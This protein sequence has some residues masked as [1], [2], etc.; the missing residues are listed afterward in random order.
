MG[1]GGDPPL[2]PPPSPVKQCVDNQYCN[3][4]S[5]SLSDI[6]NIGQFDGADSIENVSTSSSEVSSDDTVDATDD[7]IGPDNTPI[8]LTPVTKPRGQ[9]LKVLKASS[10]PLVTVLNARSL[11]N[12]HDN[13]KT[14][15]TELGVEAAI[16][17]ETWEREDKPLE[18]L[19]QMT[20]YKVHSHRR[21]KVKA[22]RQPGGACA[23]VYNE[24]RFQVTNLDVHVPKGVEAC[25]SVFKPRNKT[26]TIEN[27]AIASVYVSPNS[28]YK[29]ATIDH[30]IDTIHILR[31]KYDNKINYLIGGDLNR[32][33]INRI[34]DSYGPLRQ[35]IS[36]P[37]RHSATLENIITDLHTLYQQPEC[38]PPLLVERDKPGVCELEKLAVR[39]EA[40]CL[41]FGLKSLLHPVHS[42][43]FPVNPN[44]LT[45]YHNTP[46]R[47]HFQVNWAKTESYRMSAVPY[48]QRLLN[49]YVK[50][51]KH[52]KL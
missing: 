25:W 8:R 18:D 44:V 21:P 32:L 6:S 20:K 31:A 22:N 19:L 52:N 2:Y 42:S 51:Q 38:L 10:L 7:E 45:D 37:T 14:F 41:K 27:I 13:F 5:F 28:V 29:T 35:I 33:K 1:E 40:R 23:L 50:K 39:R 12:K 16:V 30:I 11:Y 15:L 26:D 4:D 3:S 34:L 48:I 47:E 9:Q 43:L 46:N 24:N 17:S 49:E 36:V